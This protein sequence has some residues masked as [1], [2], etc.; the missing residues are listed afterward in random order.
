MRRVDPHFEPEETD[1]NQPDGQGAGWDTVE[2]I[3]REESNRAPRRTPPP[4]PPLPLKV[5][6]YAP[7]S[8]TIDPQTTPFGVAPPTPRPVMPVGSA[9]QVAVPAPVE[10]P[11]PQKR[12]K[13]LVFFGCRG[14]AGATMLS[15]NVA[16]SLARAGASVCVVDLDLQLGDVF[17]ALD[18]EPNTSIAGLARE[19]DA[20]DAAALRRRLVRHDSGVYALS[21][22]GRLDDVDPELVE[23]LP[24]LLTF[25]LGHFDYVVADGVRDFG[26]C[27]LPVLDMADRIALV[28][29]QDVQA[30][31][32]AARV[33]QL[34]RKLGYPEQKV[35]MVVN[36]HSSKAPVEESEIERV[37]S[38]PIV[39]TVRND[40]A[41]LRQSLDEG[42]L[43]HDIARTAPVTY[44]V[45]QV[46]RALF[47]ESRP[48][49]P[50]EPRRGF[51]ARLLGRDR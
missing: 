35:Q 45:E 50:A 33:T 39:A 5:V 12:G 6:P 34:F 27:A 29:T 38:M 42:A 26:D 7:F 8:G 30:I 2:T 40:Y 47:S 48:R 25:L 28:L 10:R 4:P 15:V 51:L 17:V 19:M 9:P 21:Q 13:L 36:R 14:G 43:L 44:D 16:S 3:I 24:A 32:R 49:P 11:L 20:L 31:R 37:L 22:T 18:L 46:A 1:V 41:R 23:R